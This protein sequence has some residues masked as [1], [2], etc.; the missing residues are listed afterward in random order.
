[1]DDRELLITIMK[2]EFNS[3]R[4]EVREIHD[5]LNTKVINK[6]D[7]KDNRKNLLISCMNHLKVKESEIKIKKIVAVG[8]VV[9][10]VVGG[11]S[12]IIVTLIKIFLQ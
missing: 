1:M 11:S 3:L 9:T 7:C 5:I 12:L 2:D 8:G 4:K 10:G 6:Q